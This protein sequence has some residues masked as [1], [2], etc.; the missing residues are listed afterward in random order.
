MARRNI[1]KG[2]IGNALHSVAPDH[3]TTTADEIFDEESQM[4]Q[5]D[6]NRSTDE[7]L[8][9][10]K[11]PLGMPVEVEFELS[12]D[13]QH[14]DIAF[15][16]AEDDKV[17]LVVANPGASIMTSKLYLINTDSSVTSV[18]KNFN[19]NSGASETFTI[20]MHTAYK[21]LRFEIGSYEGTVDVQITKLT[22][23]IQT[24]EYE[25]SEIVRTEHI[26]GIAVN[27][28]VDFSNKS[29][30]DLEYTAS[31]ND[32][33]V[34][35]ATNSGSGATAKVGVNLLYKDGTT[36]GIIKYLGNGLGV[37]DSFEQTLSK[38]IIGIRFGLSVARTV[39]D[40]SVSNKN[41]LKQQ[42]DNNTDAEEI[43]TIKNELGDIVDFDIDFSSAND[44]TV[45]YVANNGD[46]I[47]ISA[48]NV[49]VNTANIGIAL[50]YTDG[51]TSSIIK[52]L[53]AATGNT[54][55][56]TLTLARDI[57]G[58]KFSLSAARTKW[59]VSVN[60]ENGLSQRVGVAEQNIKNKADKAVGKNL[61]Y[62]D[63]ANDNK[64]INS[65]GTVTEH[66]AF[67]I[68][69]KIY[70]NGH[71]K[72]T[73]NNCDGQANSYVGIYAADGSVLGAIQ[74]NGRE[75]TFD[76][77]AYPT[78]AY[79]ILTI[80]KAV[81]AVCRETMVCYGSPDMSLVYPYSDIQGKQIEYNIVTCNS[82]P[83][84]DADYTG[85]NAIRDAIAAIT[86][87]SYFKRYIL[88][89]TGLFKATLPSE[90]EADPYG[91]TQ[92]AMFWLK[93]FMYI[94]GGDRCRCILYSSLP[95]SLAECQADKP[96]F[97]KAHYAL[98]Q[99]INI[100]HFT[101]R[102][103]NVTLISRNS[104]YP[105]HIDQPELYALN[106]REIVIENC[107]LI[108]EGKYGDAVGTTSTSASG[109]G[110]PGGVKLIFRNCL[111]SGDGDLYIHDQS[112]VNVKSEY[113]FEDCIY[114]NINTPTQT[115]GVSFF[116]QMNPN[117]NILRLINTRLPKDS[118]VVATHNFYIALKDNYEFADTNHMELVSDGEAMPIFN[119]ALGSGI[120]VEAL[121][122][123]SSVRFV[124]T[125]SAFNL[126]IGNTDDTILQER[127]MYNRCQ[128]Y[129]YQWRDGATNLKAEAIGLRNVNPIKD[130]NQNYIYSIGTRLGDC[131]T[132]NKVLG[133]IINGTT[134]NVIFN[135][136][137]TALSNEAIIAEINEV[138]GAVAT[139]SVY[140]VN[141]D[142]YPI[143]DGE[144]YSLVDDV[145]SI[146]KGMGVVFTEFGVRRA[147][148][149]DKKIDGI[150]VDSGANGKSIRV[151]TKGRV[152]YDEDLNSLHAM[153]NSEH[154]YSY[155]SYGTGFGIGNTDGVFVENPDNVTLVKSRLNSVRIV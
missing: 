53:S 137:Y 54:D 91:G 14:E 49:G 108:N 140:D 17:E 135:K 110:V 78:A 60:N 87:A 62:F 145:N 97:V 25:K 115:D 42:I 6:I 68:S 125:S 57:V 106:D 134:Y 26:V 121:A 96:E 64:Y 72:I 36:S 105:L 15:D 70:L 86:D 39:W 5:N 104:R 28:I 2:N 116:S 100:A 8:I 19:L 93:N 146:L 155:Y 63:N 119:N 122:D 88:K 136:D 128:Q 13:N 73:C 44:Q 98:Y 46:T 94:D 147:K 30:A 150:A 120:R 152:C 33:I 95:S 126:I 65:A 143:Y 47:K 111:F 20:D 131:S 56:Y 123:S 52:Y 71:T 141:S 3:I 48:K 109:F 58:F 92:Y 130:E 107:S 142:W 129:G 41:G 32:I 61:Y 132:T 117:G 85:N 151:I 79:V 76:F 82:D 50:C 11:A 74:Q 139:A 133:I 77:S 23:V 4:Y 59:E 124:T 127:N 75:K 80:S 35:K 148:S 29:D 43:V 84:A 22:G 112:G 51:T 101:T 83:N 118:F 102:I 34:I 38:D 31:A 113:I 45:Q 16:I 144:V 18:I 55:S 99:P 66:S 7:Q 37:T 69:N 67:R 81:W 89:C 138:I 27:D 21:G 149:T 12:S 1:V 154:P 103:K 114:S 153:I 9:D 40:I 24:V 90:H 10:I